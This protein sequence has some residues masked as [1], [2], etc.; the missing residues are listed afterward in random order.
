MK[1][2]LLYI[3][4]LITSKGLTAQQVE[5]YSMQ[6]LNLE[7][8][9]PAYTGLKE[10]IEI[11]GVLRKQWV[12]FPGSPATTILNAHMPLFIARGGI[13]VSF[14]K[15]KIGIQQNT[16]LGIAY[17]YHK[18]IGNGTLSTGLSLHYSQFQLDGSLIR[19]PEGDYSEPGL[20]NHN[21]EKLIATISNINIPHF[22][23]GFA[24]VN[25]RFKSGITL[26]NA[27][28][29]IGK[30]KD[31]SYTYNRH[32]LINTEYAFD[33]G[34]EI[35][36]RPSIIIRTDLIKVQTEISALFEYKNNITL[37]VAFRGYNSNSVDAIPIITGIRLNDYLSLYY[38]YDIALS[39]LR[40]N[41]TGTHEIMLNYSLS[42]IIG[43]GKPPIIIYNPRTW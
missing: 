12:S 28:R 33:I 1:K 8:Y 4:L 24:F 9:N 19:T 2:A 30:K 16:S 23:L 36:L 29:P 40:T 6:M 5:Q 42:K 27:N 26:L 18:T 11:K 25:D 39:G 34:T 37:G 43:K 38:S 3:V 31:L 41:Q 13:G 21:D 17:S 15:L 7:Q 32:L 22:S 20:I 14:K 10:S 35:V